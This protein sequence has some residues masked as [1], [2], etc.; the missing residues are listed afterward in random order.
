MALCRARA[1]ISGLYCFWES[2]LL[3]TKLPCEL[4]PSVVSFLP[5]R[6]LNHCFGITA[7]TLMFQV[8]YPT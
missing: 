1:H 7:K 3:S 5:G 2:A 8:G 4:N 6:A